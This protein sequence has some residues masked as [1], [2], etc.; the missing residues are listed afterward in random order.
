VAPVAGGN[1][2]NPARPPE[3]REVGS[4]RPQGTSF[5]CIYNSGSEGGGGGRGF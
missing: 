1:C 3:G 2:K 5:E 4:N